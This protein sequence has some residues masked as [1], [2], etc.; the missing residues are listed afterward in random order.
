MYRCFPTAVKLRIHTQ[1]D[2]TLWFFEQSGT[3]ILP[4]AFLRKVKIAPVTLCCNTFGTRY[5]IK[6]TQTVCCLQETWVQLTGL[7]AKVGDMSL[8]PRIGKPVEIQAF[9]TTTPYHERFCETAW[10]CAQSAQY[11]EMPRAHVSFNEKF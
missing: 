4:I 11:S 5:G 1:S 2:A 6:M 8:T 7:D 9:G 3:C 10:R